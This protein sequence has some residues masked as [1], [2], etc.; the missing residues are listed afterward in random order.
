[1]RSMC[2]YG[3]FIHCSH[4]EIGCT[5]FMIIIYITSFAWHTAVHYTNVYIFIHTHYLY[6]VYVHVVAVFC[7]LIN[8]VITALLLL[9]S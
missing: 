7:M 3:C 6:R 4:G 1:M 5:L 8:R 9:L 2:V